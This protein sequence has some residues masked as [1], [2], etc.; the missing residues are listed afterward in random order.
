VALRRRFH[1]T[2]RVI[3]DVRAEYFNLFNHPM[4][5]GPN[6]PYTFW[7]LCAT[8]PCAGQQNGLFGKVVPGFGTLNNQGL[9]GG[10]LEGGQS[11]IYALGGPR[12]GQLSLKLQF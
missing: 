9:G 6:G 10:G 1:L 11:A 8:M 5:G 2:E 4:F 12:S 3:L 7:G